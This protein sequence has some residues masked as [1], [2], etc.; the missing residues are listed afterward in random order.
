[1]ANDQQTATAYK[2]SDLQLGMI[3][4][5]ATPSVAMTH[6]MGLAKI[7]CGSKAGVY[8]SMYYLTGEK[9]TYNW[10]HDATTS[11]V[12]S[13]TTFTNQ[14][15]KPFVSNHVCY[16]IVDGSV[17]LGGDN[18]FPADDNGNGWTTSTGTIGSG[19]YKE[20]TLSNP[21]LQAKQWTAYTIAI[22]DVLYSDGALTHYGS[23]IYSNRTAIAVVFN[24]ERGHSGDPA[25]WTHGYALGLREFNYCAWSSTNTTVNSSYLTTY[26]ALIADMAGYSKTLA[27]TKVSGFSASTFPAAYM[28]WNYSAKSKNGASNVALSGNL[29]TVGAHWFLPS[30]G[31]WYKILYNL[32]NV[33]NRVPTGA[34]GSLNQWVW[35]YSNSSSDSAT[36]RDAINTYIIPIINAGYATSNI[37]PRNTNI[38]SEATAVRKIPYISFPE[39]SSAYYDN[40]YKTCSETGT[41]IIS[42]VLFGA[43][44]DLTI[45]C[46]RTGDGYEKTPSTHRDSMRPIIGF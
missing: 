45:T 6:K 9:N 1:M 28:A 37:S 19:C 2:G 3:S 12:Y 24:T 13:S 10:A 29:T 35:T 32:G 30:C 7:N 43:G 11:T 15:L 34:G 4:A 20:T 25:K 31:Q 18:E 5:G 38:N 27:I 44:P 33:K 23:T 41:N 17:S 14:T 26:D 16:Y 40:T 39:S 46:G 42:V 8:N 22:G 36:A 21:T